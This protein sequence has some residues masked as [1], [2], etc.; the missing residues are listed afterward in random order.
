MMNVKTKKGRGAQD[1]PANQFD[2]QHVVKEFLEAIDEWPESKDTAE[3]TKFLEVYPKSIVNKIMSPDVGMEWSANPYQG[4][5]H[6]CIYCYARNSHEFWGYSA[7]TDFEQQILVKANAAELLRTQ[8]EAKSWRVAPVVFSGN[9]DCYQ[10]A[11]RKFKVTR[12]MLEVM[13]DLK[14]PVGIITKNALLLRDLD[15]LEPLNELNLVHVHVSLTTLQEPLRLA[16]EPRTSSIANRLRL[17][18]T[19]A[20]LGFEVRVL[21]APIIPGLNS[22]EL[23]DLVKAA[24]NSGAAKVDYHTVRLNGHVGILFEG[25]LQHHFPDRANKVLNGIRSL[26]EGQLNDSQFGRRMSGTGNLALQI[27]DSFRLAVKMHLPQKE[28]RPYNLSLFQ[29]GGEQMQLKLF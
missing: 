6:G 21:L 4:C 9:T 15:I 20:K 27:R 29:P 3:K 14:H 1:N 13:L 22:H 17:I 26:H 2:K 11:E 16:M 24:A 5:E 10:P 12:S 7:G 18:E 23:F 8:L 19:L 25:W 28:L